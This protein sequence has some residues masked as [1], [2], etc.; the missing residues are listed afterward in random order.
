MRTSVLPRSRR[1]TLLLVL[2]LGWSLPLAA[3]YGAVGNPTP[4]EVLVVYNSAWPT[5]STGLGINDSQQVAEYYAARRGIPT[6]NLLG[7]N[8]ATSGGNYYYF[9]GQYPNFESEVLEPIQHAV[10][11]PGAAYRVILLCYGVPYVVYAP[12]GQTYSID[13][14]LMGLNYWASDGSNLGWSSNPYLDPAPGFDPSPGHF[15]PSVVTFNGTT[16]YLV[17]RLDGPRGPAG[18]MELVDQAIFA[19][20]YLTT[21]SG[22]YHGTVYVDSRY[23]QNDGSTPYTDAFLATQAAVQSGDYDTGYD[24]ADQCIAWGEHAALGTGLPLKWENT[25]TAIQIGQTG[26]T[27]SDGT[28]A[29]TAPDAILYGGWYNYGTYHDVWGWLPGSVAC[30]LN[31]DSL[32]EGTLRSASSGCFG[33]SALARGATCVCGVLSEPY[34]NG[35]HRPNILLYY[36]LAGYSFAEAAGLS[37]PAICWQPIAIGDPLYAP[38]RA[39]PLVL[40]TT[41][42]QLD[43]GFPQVVVGGQPTDRMILLQL[44]EPPSAPSVAQASITYGPTTAYGQTATSGEGYWRRPTVS[45]TGLTAGTTYHYQLTLTDPV[46]NHTTSGD[47]QFTVPTTP[48]TGPTITTAAQASPSP[49][50]AGTCTVSVAASDPAGAAGL[51]YSWSVV[52]WGAAPIQVL[53]NRATTAG[54][55]TVT[56]TA[57]GTYVLRATAIDASGL[58]ATSDVQVTVTGLGPGTTGGSGSTTSTGATAGSSSGGGGGHG[59]GLGGAGAGL[60]LLVVQGWRRRVAHRTA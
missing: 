10:T 18:A 11:Q 45:L 4:A 19:D 54:Q 28:S 29:L 53:P 39:K 57:L 60:L 32:D 20:L 8:C 17:S 25:T 22:G 3:A 44:A 31:S 33:V 35:H 37:N 43:A 30:D 6:A 12:S 15:D 40:D 48:G 26:A 38:F 50:T 49:V 41:A 36:L 52:G 5:D 46:G 9:T 58:S 34:L 23:G 13:G 7:V 56:F 47:L 24:T 59:C 55:A 42:P 2:G 51:T 21:A 1:W 16:M 27:Y 14:L